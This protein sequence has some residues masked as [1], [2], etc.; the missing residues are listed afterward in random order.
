MTDALPQIGHSQLEHEGLALL[1]QRV[2][3]PPSNG[4]LGFIFREL[5]AMDFGIDAQIEVVTE[6]WQGGKT[7]TGRLLSVQVKTGESYF[8]VDDG[9]TWSLYLRKETVNYWR[10]HSVPVLLVLVNPASKMIYWTR[11]DAA[12]HTETDKGFRIRVKKANLL[13]ASARFEL[14][15]LAENTTEENRRLA[16]L[17]A[18]LPII[19]KLNEGEHVVIDI[20][21]WQNKSSGR[22]DYWIGVPGRNATGDGPRDLVPL[23]SGMVIGTGGDVLRAISFLA[24]WADTEQDEDFDQAA[25]EQL[26][27][28][29]LAETGTWDSEDQV[30]IDSHGT[31]KEWVRRRREASDGLLAYYEDGEVSQYRLRL[32]ANELGRG[33]VL[34]SAF[35]ATGPSSDT[36]R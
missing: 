31:F 30:Y 6:D 20:R 10:N 34:V 17:Q 16:R 29:Y 15:E 18:D 1:K 28:E 23:T 22:M 12:D 11:G 26:Y 24:P 2:V 8:G 35:L 27:D 32:R 25:E 9:D 21:H 4:G 14:V 13:D 5:P 19:V 33:F 36:E 3:A 7:A